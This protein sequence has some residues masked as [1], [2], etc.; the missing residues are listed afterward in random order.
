MPAIELITLP[1]PG[2]K[3]D[4]NKTLEE[5]DFAMCVPPG[6]YAMCLTQVD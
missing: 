5:E 2:Q 1:K 6:C 4:P 3:Y